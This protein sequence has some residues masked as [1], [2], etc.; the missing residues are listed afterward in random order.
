TPRSAAIA[1]W[2]C[3]SRYRPEKE[4]AG[5]G[6]TSVNNKL[7]GTDVGSLGLSRSSSYFRQLP[8]VV[9]SN[10]HRIVFSIIFFIVLRLKLKINVKTVCSLCRHLQPGIPCRLGID[11]HINECIIVF[12]PID[13]ITPYQG[14]RSVVYK[15]F[16]HPFGGQ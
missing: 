3:A 8:S 6:V 5:V 12:G 1:L 15:T 2:N 11:I 10:T 16:F 9:S 4:E 13:Q 7:G 14:Y